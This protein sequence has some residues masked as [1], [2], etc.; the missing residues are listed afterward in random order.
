MHSIHKVYGQFGFNLDLPVQVNSHC[1]A[2]AYKDTVLP[3]PALN[4]RVA[5][6]QCAILDIFST[7][8]NKFSGMVGACYAEL[9]PLGIETLVVAS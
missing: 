6:N 3:L 9:I 5:G 4:C 2:F 8:E 7:E 1:I